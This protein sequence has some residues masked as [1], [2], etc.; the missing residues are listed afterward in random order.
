MQKREITEPRVKAVSQRVVEAA[1]D[2]LGDK[3]DKVILYG[4]YV[5]GDY[6]RDSDIDF[7]ILADVTQEEASIKRSDIRNQIPDIDLE[8]DLLVSLH[9]TG[10]E[11]FNKFIDT[12]PF[13]TN[14]V[15]EGVVLND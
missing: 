1:K 11:I 10:S 3:L 2:T 12:L 7:F 14:V 4:S 9:V 13:Y 6:D 8:F 15:R 5:R